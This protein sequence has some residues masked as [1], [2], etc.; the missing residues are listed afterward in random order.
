MGI[1]MIEIESSNITIF[2]KGKIVARRVK[3]RKDAQELL[4]NILPCIR[5]VK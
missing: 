1:A 2:G 5:R 4:V 3:D